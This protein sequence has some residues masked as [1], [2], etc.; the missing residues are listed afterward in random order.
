MPPHTPK[1]ENNNKKTIAMKQKAI[2]I[3]KI[4]LAI[5][6]GY[7]AIK[8]TQLILWLAYYSGIQV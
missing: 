2:T 7:I 4:A 5:I 1:K 3:G 6:A 8:A